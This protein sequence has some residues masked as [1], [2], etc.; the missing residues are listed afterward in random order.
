MQVPNQPAPL[1]PGVRFPPPL[2]FAV[3]WLI[4]FGF[5]QRMPLPLVPAVLQMGERLTGVLLICTALPVL[6]WA[7]YR[8]VRAGTSI[9]PHRPADAFVVGGPYRV[10]R[11]PMYV[12][13]ATLH[14]GSALMLDSLWLGAG[15]PI[16]MMLIQ[17]LVIRREERYLTHR[18]GQAYLD[19]TLR[20][21][22]WL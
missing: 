3:P 17:R 15:V 19:Y 6:G 5:G 22:R 20:V 11:N 12:A 18:F 2:C 1:S 4:G 16:G 21:R 13:L 9:L 14:L 7:M 10:S 8:F